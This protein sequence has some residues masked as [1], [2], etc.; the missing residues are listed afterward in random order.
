MKARLERLE[1]LGVAAFDGPGLRFVRALIDRAAQ[2]DGPAR[3]QLTAR[4]TTRLDD[5]EATFETRRREAREALDALRRGAHGSDNELEQAFAR[6]ELNQVVREARRRLQR[7]E[8]AGYATALA[9]LKRLT[10]Q[11]RQRSVPLSEALERQLLIAKR[12]PPSDD[13]AA[14]ALGDQVAHALF[15]HAASTVRATVAVARAADNAPSEAGPYN[16]RVLSALALAA[17]ETLSPAYLRAYVAGLED[18]AAL[19]C[20]TESRRSKRR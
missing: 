10:E 7:L 16:P 3:A 11:A 14:R 9:R 12:D 15:R 13:R 17:L 4:A 19:R 5:L 6:G 2:F 8:S 1:E 18:L 20:L